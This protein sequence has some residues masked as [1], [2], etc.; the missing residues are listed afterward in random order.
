MLWIICLPLN[1]LIDYFPLI[2]IKNKKAKCDMLCV[3]K[4][5]TI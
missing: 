3:S 4:A 1:L 5:E 2:D